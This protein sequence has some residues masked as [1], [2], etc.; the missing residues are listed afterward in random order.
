MVCQG[1][2]SAWRTGHGALVRIGETVFISK[3]APPEHLTHVTWE[4]GAKVRIHVRLVNGTGTGAQEEAGSSFTRRIWSSRA[5]A[6]R[7]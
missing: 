5:L 3:A 2:L 1:R 7:L 6:H 4:S